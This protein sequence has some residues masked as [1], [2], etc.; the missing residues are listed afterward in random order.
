[1]SRTLMH[2]AWPEGH[3]AARQVALAPA[4]TSQCGAEG[5]GRGAARAAPRDSRRQ[6]AGPRGRQGCRPEGHPSWTACCST[7]RASRRWPMPWPAS[8]RWPIRLGACSRTGRG[9][10]A[11]LFERVATPLG[12]IAVIFESRPNVTADAGALC[13]KSGNAAILRGG[14]DSFRSSHRAS[15]PAMR[16]RARSPPAC[17]ARRSSS[18]RRGTAPR[19]ARCSPGLGGSRRRRRAA[20][21]QEPRRAG[22][23][24]GARAG[25]RAI[26]KATAMS[27]SMTRRTSTWRR[28][29][30][31]QRQ[32][33]PHRRLRRGRDPAGR[34]GLRRL[35]IWPPL[36][37][38]CCCDAGCA[39]RGDDGVHGADPRVAAGDRRGLVDRI[40]RPRSSRRRWWTGSTRRS[41]MS[42]ATAR[43]IPMPSSPRTRPPPTRF[44]A[45]VDSAI[46]LHNASTQFADGGEFGFG[47]EIGIATGRMHARGPVGVEQLCSFKYR[48]HGSRP[49][50]AVTIPSDAAAPAGPCAG[51]C[52]SACSAASFNPAHDG[53]RLASLTALRRLQLDRVWWLVTPG[54]PLKD[55]AA[56]PPPGR[57]HP[58]ARARSPPMPASTSPASRRMLRTRYTADTL[59]RPEA[60]RC[61]GVRFVWIMGSDN[62]AGFHRWNEW[63]AI[64]RMMPIAVIDRPGS[65][66]RAHALRRPPT[67]SRAGVL[68]ESE[69]ALH[70][71]APEPPAWVF[72]HGKRSTPRP[73]CANWQEPANVKPPRLSPEQAAARKA[74]AVLGIMPCRDC[75]LSRLRFV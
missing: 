53:H 59:A 31:A 22:A 18:C 61:S 38:A 33:A 35:P 11:S 74:L 63:R 17:R 70:W 71:P 16:R 6:R 47:A 12:V 26:S 68:S 37:T 20:R 40:S 64:A 28:Q 4:E 48:V 14:S 75:V 58:T 1:M 55:N 65:T 52:A 73:I 3:A 19:W 27:T 36:V 32:A 2:G 7:R 54:N 46:V 8:P 45:E 69:A 51:A 62:L 41:S 15:P 42:S 25:L 24:R 57:A 5:H 29:H 44:L 56:L 49:D 43:T 13:L 23:E 50:P 30:P 72:L 34:P 9:R 39:V 60:C 67:G 21:R 66:H 10:T